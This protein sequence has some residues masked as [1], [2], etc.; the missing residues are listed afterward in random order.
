MS[1]IADL[2]GLNASMMASVAA[3]RTA[4]QMASQSIALLSAA[5][6][7]EARMPLPYSSVLDKLA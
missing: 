6:G 4:S 2:P 1:A 7:G 5:S 3:F